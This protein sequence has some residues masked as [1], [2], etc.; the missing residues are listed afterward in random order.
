CTPNGTT[1]KVTVDGPSASSGDVTPL[2]VTFVVHDQTGAVVS[3]SA[4]MGADATVMLDVPSCGM[5]TVVDTG[6]GDPRA[7]TWMGVQPGDH[8]LHLN[9]FPPST[10]H[11]VSVQLAAATGATEYQVLA[12]CS[13]NHVSFS[14]SATA[15]TLTLNPQCT[16]TSVSVLVTTTAPTGSQMALVTVPLAASGTTNVAISGYQTPATST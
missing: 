4:V 15:T 16:G 14:S 6:S 7:V 10:P 12:T 3:R 1:G 2:Q 11:A 13:P 5:V 8:L 9:R